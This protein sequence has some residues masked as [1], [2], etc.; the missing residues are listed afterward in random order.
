M[1]FCWWVYTYCISSE[2]QESNKFSNDY[3]HPPH[4]RVGFIVKAAIAQPI[5]GRQTA[6]SSRHILG[7]KQQRRHVR[8][9][10]PAA[11]AGIICYADGARAV[12]ALLHSIFGR[13]TL[14]TDYRAFI[15]CCH[16]VELGSLARCVLWPASV[17][18]RVKVCVGCRCSWKECGRGT[19][20]MTTGRGSPRTIMTSR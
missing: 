5:Q 14:N 17:K 2:G 18:Q 20:W 16:P 8:H 15:L 7:A 9:D 1:K 4:Q 11:C 12:W 13:T 3:V 10:C 6:H 19:R